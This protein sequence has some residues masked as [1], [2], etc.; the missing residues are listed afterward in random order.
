M[1][2]KW[3][4]P[5]V[6]EKLPELKHPEYFEALDKAKAQLS[7]GRYK[8]ALATLHTAKDVD[9]LE[10]ALVRG[11]ALNALGRTDEALAV[12]SAEGV[13]NAPRVQVLRAQV[14]ADIGKAGEAIALLQ[15]HL[16]AHPTS[17]AGHYHLGAISE[18]VGDIATA[19]AAYQWFFEEPQ[20]FLDKWLGED[21][22]AFESAEDVTLIGR[23]IDRHATL[24]G[25]YRNNH[26][27]HNI[28]LNMFVRAYDVIDRGYVPAHVAAASY[29]VTHDDKHRATQEL[30][31]VLKANPNEPEALELLGRIAIDEHNYGEALNAADALRNVNP[32][33][34]SADILEIHALLRGD[35]SSRVSDIVQ[36]LLSK[37]PRN[38]EALALAAAAA[39]ARNDDAARDQYLQ[40]ADSVAPGS[41]LALATLA[42]VL[43]DIHRHDA[44]KA[45]SA[46]AVERAPLWPLPRHQLG[47]LH[48]Q[49]AEEEEARAQFEA[50]YELDPFNVATVNYLRLLDDMKGYA[51]VETPNFV[52]VF[53]PQYDA[54]MGEYLGDFMEFVHGEVTEHFAY[55]PKRKTV[56]EVFPTTDSFSVRTAGI[57][58]AETYG[59]AFGPVITAV[60]PRAGATMGPFNFA[61][62]LRHEF[63]HVINLAQ[64]DYR[65]P[66]WLTEGLATWQEGVP[67][68]FAFVP[69]QIYDVVTKGKLAP[70]ADLSGTLLRGE[71][72]IGGEMMYMQ[73]FWVGRFIT[74]KYG[75]DALLKLLEGYRLAK[76]DDDAFR[77]GIGKPTTEFDGE[78]AAWAK[79]QVKDWG[80][81]PATEA[82]FD[83]LAR[84][85]EELIAAGAFEQATDVWLQANKLQPMNPLPHRRL[86]GLHIRQGNPRDALPHLKAFLPLELAENRY[87]KAIARI[88]RDLGE[89][90]NAVKYGMEAVYVNP[91][92]AD[93]H[94][95][96]IELYEK[97][98][99]QDGIAKEKRVLAMLEE[100]KKQPKP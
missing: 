19:T 18:T 53:D 9:P 10:A 74:E 33:S 79:E 72:K 97:T 58:G 84:S 44:A 85:G 52:I 80:Y 8:L 6:P 25:G 2:R 36:R 5:L 50:A 63:T 90:D 49:L 16:Q 46:V 66:R 68:R 41:A 77:H 55:A 23:A 48:M 83:E 87:A 78:F 86:A 38:L 61:R 67:F 76:S 73:G 98:G 20:R 88:Y 56:L 35:R 12:L 32:N 93:G 89:M 34:A 14:L 30:E 3:I 54:V 28:V 94:E 65:C 96:L 40:R 81:D 91:Y 7:A 39:M 100:L 71:S 51:R 26:D 60:A 75:H 24:T 21:P 57:P 31:A 22:T 1:P 42:N 99:N 95:L 59:A 47:K 37:R 13:A 4:E 11:A 27:L 82:K 45:Y 17:I 15:A 64:T 92:D 70:I 62:V 43:T 29:F 69:K